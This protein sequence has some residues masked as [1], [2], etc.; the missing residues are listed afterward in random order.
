M[1]HAPRRER[2][3]AGEVTGRDI[4]APRATNALFGWWVCFASLYGA[5]IA[6]AAVRA[7]ANFV[8]LVAF[9]MTVPPVALLAAIDAT[10]QRLPRVV[11][12]AT[13]LAVLPLLTLASRGPDSSA[14]A[15]LWGSLSMM[16][17][18][19][20]VRVAG[21]GALGAG[22]L[23]FAPLLGA[24]A[25]WFHPGLALAAWAISAVMGGIA[26]VVLLMLRRGRRSR[27][28]YGPVMLA[29]LSLALV[30]LT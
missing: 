18:V 21:R 10:T 20:V 1:S 15:A 28:A 30:T 25:G 4:P 6:V 3:E 8:A 12:Y 17:V 5:S 14:W 26:G 22:D 29:G 27:F 7:D 24:I 23:H 11:S 2:H 13:L 9:G 19:A 16:V